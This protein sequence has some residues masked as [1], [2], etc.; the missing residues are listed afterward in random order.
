MQHFHVARV[1]F[2]QGLQR[3]NPDLRPTR[4]HRRFLQKQICLAIVGFRFQNFLQHFNCAFGILFEF[5]LRLHHANR[6]RRDVEKTLLSRFAFRDRRASQQ[7][8]AREKLGLLLENFLEERNRV[9]EIAQLNGANRFEPKR[10][11]PFAQFLLGFD[12]HTCSTAYHKTRCMR[13]PRAKVATRAGP[14][15][16]SR[17]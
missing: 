4:R 13:Q 5:S 9:T 14:R 12:G 10:A 17:L 7:L 11:Q 3:E 6:R 2:E 1:F 8:A 16:L 15:R